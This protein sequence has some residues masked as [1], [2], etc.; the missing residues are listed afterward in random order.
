[1]ATIALRTYLEEIRSYIDD[2]ATNQALAHLKHL[3]TIYPKS[4]AVYRLMGDAFLKNADLAS[5]KEMYQR[6]LSAEPT[7]AAAHAGLATVLSQRD[8]LTDAIWHAERAFEREP[9]NAVVRDQLAALYKTRD[10]QAP[11]RIL[12]T[13]AALSRLYLNGDLY[14]QAIA[15][16]QVAL[17]EQPDRT[18]LQLILAEAQWRSGKTEA[19]TNSCEEL[20][21]RLPNCRPAHHMLAGIW[22]EAG[23]FERSRPHQ[24]A[25]RDLDPYYKLA[26]D[27]TEIDAADYVA[28]A[29]VEVEK[30]SIH[31]RTTQVALPSTVE[32]L[33]A[34]SEIANIEEELA[35][36]S[37]L[38]DTA[39]ALSAVVED[40]QPIIPPEVETLDEVED[41][42]NLDTDEV[43]TDNQSEAKEIAFPS[44]AE[45]EQELST[46]IEDDTAPE[47]EVDIMTGNDSIFQPSDEN[48]GEN[49]TP[50]WFNE[51]GNGLSDTGG[52]ASIF[53]QINDA[54]DE[55]DQSLGDMLQPDEAMLQN[56][57]NLSEEDANI[58]P[59]EN[60][61]GATDDLPDWLRAISDPTPDTPP[62]PDPI[63]IDPLAELVKPPASI[64]EPVMPAIDSPLV[65][66]EPIAEEIMSELDATI[67]PAIELVSAQAEAPVIEPTPVPAPKADT[68]EPQIEKGELPEW[69]A[70]FGVPSGKDALS[71]EPIIGNTTGQTASVSEEGSNADADD[72]SSASFEVPEMPD[73]LPEPVE[74]VRQ[75]AADSTM[76]T[77]KATANVEDTSPDWLR[78]PEEDPF[79]ELGGGDLDVPDW[80]HQAM[81][82]DGTTSSQPAVDMVIEPEDPP[83][84]EA[85][86]EIPNP[87]ADMEAV[88]EKLDADIDSDFDAFMPPSSTEAESVNA[89][90]DV[91]A[92]SPALPPIEIVSEDTI[93][94]VTD[95]LP[96]EV[97]EVIEE[98]ITPEFEAPVPDTS[99]TDNFE[100]PALEEI[101]VPDVVPPAIE[102]LPALE[103][104]DP[105][106]D[107]LAPPVI[108]TPDVEAEPSLK[109]LLSG[110]SF[111]EMAGMEDLDEDDDDDEATSLPDLTLE[112]DLAATETTETA[113]TQFPATS[114]IET[115]SVE[116]ESQE[117]LPSLKS[118]LGEV[119]FPEMEGMDDLNDDDDDD[120]E[121]ALS[122]LTLE[123]DL[124][125]PTM[126]ELAPQVDESVETAELGLEKLEAFIDEEAPSPSDVTNDLAPSNPSWLQ[127]ILGE[128]TVETP[129][130]LTEDDIN[131]IFAEASQ[132][133][134]AQAVEAEVTSDTDDLVEETAAWLDSIQDEIESKPTQ[135]EAKVEA[136]AAEAPDA[137]P[138]EDLPQWLKNL[139]DPENDV[140]AEDSASS[141]GE[142]AISGLTPL[143]L[144]S[145]EPEA[146]EAKPV[147][148]TRGWQ[149]VETTQ[150]E[151]TVS[152]VDTTTAPVV[153]DENEITLEPLGGLSAISSPTPPIADISTG[154]SSID[155]KIETIADEVIAPKVEESQPDPITKTEVAAAELDTLAPEMPEVTAVE[156]EPVQRT[157]TEAKPAEVKK[158]EPPKV[159]MPAANA[160]TVATSLEEIDALKAAR[161]RKPQVKVSKPSGNLSENLIEHAHGLFDSGDTDRAYDVFQ[162]LVKSGKNLERV[163][164]HLEVISKNKKATPLWMQ[165]LGDAYMRGDQLQKAL[166]AYK[167]ALASF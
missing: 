84:I 158:P 7:D 126:S 36:Q 153:A 150:V 92:E 115:P 139:S 1:M 32:N 86:P 70:P 138:A 4:I 111:P 66:A 49:N 45:T 160:P 89:I 156:P 152:P 93:K 16:C 44:S 162:K 22:H 140:A 85:A 133:E 76:P 18:D 80:L 155:D 98:F 124:E 25:L 47:T 114:E 154:L 97:E 122:Q 11:E 103:V 132:Q 52:L 87:F 20:L 68:T 74:T 148:E 65:E 13:R 106:V 135:A 137:E 99:V 100:L 46:F 30:L 60:I 48:E 102:E 134:E 83:A 10:G 15:E 78:K 43:E 64:S 130:T 118:L 145:T 123:E 105:V 69:L 17:Q 163:T 142:I 101:S 51:S 42:N 81:Q 120:V 143:D 77:V 75:N 121:T 58:D 73:W 57:F 50:N 167:S 82:A 2:G 33:T 91:T 27:L 157:I 23:V 3:V 159:S 128:P 5:A 55:P 161:A 94:P 53:G 104:V 79:S 62:D 146:K 116:I 141:I 149:R 67:E 108:E 63:R 14:D 9:S 29:A 88:A 107:E 35:Q 110:I 144:G 164:A 24:L 90:A 8:E 19:A 6:V 12:L 166:E 54:E 147:E 56:I 61:V 72:T 39:N 41:S 165:L 95:E 112:S 38:E 34:S 109:S 131:N 28:A 113:N 117:E 127:D 119:T 125:L 37:E 26:E 136:I 96:M 31:D 151:E 40:T 71:M 21:K 59:A 129:Q